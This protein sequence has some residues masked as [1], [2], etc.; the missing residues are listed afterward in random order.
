MVLYKYGQISFASSQCNSTFP[1]AKNTLDPH[2]VHLI[3]TKIELLTGTIA[4]RDFGLGQVNPFCIETL[5]F[6]SMFAD[7]EYNYNWIFP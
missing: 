5:K 3:E 1:A 2:S 6:G 4:Y 7:Y